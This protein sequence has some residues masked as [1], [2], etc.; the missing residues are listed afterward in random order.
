MS[1]IVAKR[2]QPILAKAASIL[3]GSAGVAWRSVLRG[4]PPERF[5]S[6]NSVAITRLKVKKKGGLISGFVAESTTKGRS[7]Y[8][9]SIMFPTAG[10]TDKVKLSCN[11]AD[12]VYRWEYA[13]FKQGGADI[14]YGDGTAPTTTNPGLSLGACKHI[15]ALDQKVRERGLL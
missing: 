7:G 3:A 6:A 4:T 12:F 11:C 1:D 9:T 14:Q 15:I 2:L 5:T 10:K 13:L 8:E